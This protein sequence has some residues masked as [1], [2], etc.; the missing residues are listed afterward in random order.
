MLKSSQVSR[1]PCKP[2][3]GGEPPGQAPAFERFA[4]ARRLMLAAYADWLKEH[5]DERDASIERDGT[6]FAMEQLR[7]IAEVAHV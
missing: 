7:W 5:P 3:A 4:A 2:Q 6:A 1:V